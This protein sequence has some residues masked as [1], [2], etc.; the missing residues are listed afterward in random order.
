MGSIQHGSHLKHQ[1]SLRKA[2]G[3]HLIKSNLSR[4]NT[5][6]C[7]WFSAKFGIVYAFQCLYFFLLCLKIM[8]PVPSYHL[9]FLLRIRHWL[10][11]I[12]SLLAIFYD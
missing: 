7:L 2:T 3:C 11:L 6:P 4:S 1:P 8:D 10:Q 5:K 9:D 12:H